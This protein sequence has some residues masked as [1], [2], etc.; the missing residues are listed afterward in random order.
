[1]LPATAG[2]R[3]RSA[4]QASN[5][6][7]FESCPTDPIRKRGAVEIDALTA[8]D[9]SLS[10]ERQM[11]GVFGHQHMRDGRL[12]RQ[13]GV[14]LRNDLRFDVIRPVPPVNLRPDPWLLE[15]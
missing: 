12:G 3:F 9:L 8:H 1:M 14:V 4:I 13:S 6:S 11:V 5:R 2:R 15:R 7:P 10:V